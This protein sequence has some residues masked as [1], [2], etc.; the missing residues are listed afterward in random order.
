MT[1]DITSKTDLE[2]IRMFENIFFSKNYLNPFIV[3]LQN[4]FY[5]FIQKLMIIIDF[6]SC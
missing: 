1:N 5:L 4:P 2:T 3:F 6:T